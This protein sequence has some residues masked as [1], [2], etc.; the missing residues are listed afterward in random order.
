ME[1][2][3]AVGDGQA[4]SGTARRAVT[5]ITDAIEREEDIAERVLGNALAVIAD[6]DYS[7]ASVLANAIFD[8]YVHCCAFGGVAEGVANHVFDGAG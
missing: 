3:G 2:D 7:I 5:G 1:S 8:S 4:E 6:P